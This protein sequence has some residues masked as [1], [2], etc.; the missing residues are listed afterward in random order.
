MLRAATCSTVQ[1]MQLPPAA[2]RGACSY[3]MQLRAMQLPPAAIRCACRQY[4]FFRPLLAPQPPLRQNHFGRHGPLFPARP[5]PPAPAKLECQCTAIACDID[6]TIINQAFGITSKSGTGWPPGWAPPERHVD[7]TDAKEIIRYSVELCD[8]AV[9]AA[10]KN[11]LEITNVVDQKPPTQPPTPMLSQ[12]SILAMLQCVWNRR[13]IIIRTAV[14]LCCY[15]CHAQ[16]LPYGV[17]SSSA[18]AVVTTTMLPGPLDSACTQRKCT[19][20]SHV[21]CTQVHLSVQDYGFR[22]PR[23]DR[24]GVL[25]AFEPGCRFQDEPEHNSSLFYHINIIVPR[26]DLAK[27]IKTCYPV[28]YDEDGKPLDEIRSR[29]KPVF[30]TAAIQPYAGAS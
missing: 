26:K 16:L 18:A 11:L 7:P 15:H 10:Q 24:D 3:Q 29:F 2:T 9:R 28:T 17:S 12:Q 20:T 21:H 13:A 14:R 5:R 4:A 23:P 27:L 19:S 6:H 22:I 1:R 8:W 30:T 25:R